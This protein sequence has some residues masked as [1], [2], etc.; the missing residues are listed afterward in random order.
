[1]Q[2]LL[3][4]RYAR[5]PYER[6]RKHAEVAE[7]LARLLAGDESPRRQAL[8][9]VAAQFEQAGRPIGAR[10]LAAGV[11]LALERPADAGRLSTEAV[12]L[13]LGHGEAVPAVRTEEIYFTHAR[14]LAA[15]GSPDGAEWFRKAADVVRAK[16]EKIEDPAQRDSY[17]G[18]VA[19]NREILGAETKTTS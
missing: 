6:K 19:L 5:S 8:L 15:T 13:L 7:A 14:V 4:D 12:E 3:Y 9:E 2:K 18:R 17:V 16:V 11:A 10:S 1:M